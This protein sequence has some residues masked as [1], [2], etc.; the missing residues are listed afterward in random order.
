MLTIKL[1]EVPDND[2]RLGAVG[3]GYGI[4]FGN[5]GGEK[6]TLVVGLVLKHWC[7]KLCHE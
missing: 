4:G 3:E 5:T 2:G 6:L 7:Q 1:K